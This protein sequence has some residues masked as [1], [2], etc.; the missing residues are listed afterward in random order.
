MQLTFMPSKKKPGENIL[1][2]GYLHY[3]KKD[4]K[5][6]CYASDARLNEISLETIDVENTTTGSVITFQ[7]THKDTDGEEIYGWNYK[8]IR[9]HKFPCTLLIIND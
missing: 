2:Q 1:G 7:Y 9:G 6:S 3:D 5:F 8:A 4:S